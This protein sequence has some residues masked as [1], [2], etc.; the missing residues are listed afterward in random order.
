MSCLIKAN[1]IWAQ[2]PV[3]AI[4]PFSFSQTFLVQVLS[5]I[6]NIDPHIC[7]VQSDIL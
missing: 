2:H 3:L 4:K 5:E 6:C 1:T 7:S